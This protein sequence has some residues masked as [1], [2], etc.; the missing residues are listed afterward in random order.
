MEPTTLSPTPGQAVNSVSVWTNTNKNKNTNKN[1]NTNANAKRNTNT[2]TRASLIGLS[3]SM[4]L[5]VP[6]GAVVAT[7]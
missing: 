7:L 6:N 3:T 2:N 4:L 1:T 5:L